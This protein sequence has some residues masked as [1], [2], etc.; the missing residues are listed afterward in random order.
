MMCVTWYA[1]LW[2]YKFVLNI[3]DRNI[4]VVNFIHQAATKILARQLVR[5]RQQIANLQSSRAQMRGIATHTQVRR[6][7][8]VR[9]R[10]YLFHILAQFLWVHCSWRYLSFFFVPLFFSFLLQ[11][12]QAHSSV[13]V[14]MKGA[15]TAMSAM[16]KVD[17]KH[18]RIGR[19]CF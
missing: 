17:Y 11:A 16:N 9:L 15:T 4:S 5:L 14:G 18:S 7:K 1:W 13:A 19:K 2:Y 12:M 8:S 10:S 6:W 3:S